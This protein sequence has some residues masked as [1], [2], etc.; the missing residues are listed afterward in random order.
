MSTEAN[1][2]AA[3]R[4]SAMLLKPLVPQGAGFAIIVFDINTGDGGSMS[5]YS[6]ES[7]ADLLKV[8]RDLIVQLESKPVIAAPPPPATASVVEVK[9]ASVVGAKPRAG[10]SRGR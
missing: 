8:L 2:E 1:K 9:P 3:E 7:R 6:H 4:I 5:L 10:K